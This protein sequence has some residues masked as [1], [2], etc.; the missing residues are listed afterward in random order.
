SEEGTRQSANDSP[1]AANIVALRLEDSFVVPFLGFGPR[2][3]N[4]SALQLAAPFLQSRTAKRW[5]SIGW[6]VSPSSVATI[7]L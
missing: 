2:I 1:K 6:G 7:P 4:D 3:S 5:H